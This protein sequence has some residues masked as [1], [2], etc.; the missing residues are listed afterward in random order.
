MQ[1]RFI[2]DLSTSA[3]RRASRSTHEPIPKS[4]NWPADINHSFPTESHHLVLITADEDPTLFVEQFSVI[5]RV[6]FVIDNAVVVSSLLQNFFVFTYQG[7]TKTTWL[8]YHGFK[9]WIW[10]VV[11]SFDTHTV[12]TKRCRYHISLTLKL[13][14]FRLNRP[15]HKLLQNQTV[16][17]V[18]T[19]SAAAV[20]A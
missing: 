14:Q 6:T 10:I 3:H 15:N 2:L 8:A 5:S 17:Y 4:Q 11:V 20:G 19:K 9:I 18:G 12:L 1:K 7:S 13:L 16:C